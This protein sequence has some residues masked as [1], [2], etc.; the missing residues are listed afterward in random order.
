MIDHLGWPR[1]GRLARSRA[2]QLRGKVLLICEYTPKAWQ[3]YY[4]DPNVSR[5]N[6]QIGQDVGDLVL[7]DSNMEDYL[8]SLDTEWIDDPEEAGSLMAEYFS[9]D[10]PERKPPFWHRRRP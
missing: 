3:I 4:V 10:E 5:N 9:D 1:E 7:E 6:V 2:G 8:N